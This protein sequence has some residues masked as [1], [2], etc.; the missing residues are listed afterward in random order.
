MPNL[1]E[2]DL[3]KGYPLLAQ[4]Y[5]RKTVQRVE[6]CEEKRGNFQEYM[7]RKQLGL[8]PSNLVCGVMYMEGIK[9]VNLIETSLVVIEI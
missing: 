4:S 5:F 2:I 3:Q 9:F 7:S 8:F 1:K 6:I